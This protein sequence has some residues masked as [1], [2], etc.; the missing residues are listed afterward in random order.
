MRA[1]WLPIKFEL[2]Q[3]EGTI[4]IQGLSPIWEMLDEQIQKTM[5]IAGSPYV[6]YLVQDVLYWKQ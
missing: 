4:I 1:E 5:I 6:K 3:F 2:I